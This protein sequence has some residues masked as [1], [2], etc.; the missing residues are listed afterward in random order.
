MV[1][2]I[3]KICDEFL[4]Y[5]SF[6]FRQKSIEDTKSISKS[7]ANDL[8]RTKS[9][10]DKPITHKKST[11]YVGRSRLTSIEDVVDEVEEKQSR[12]KSTTKG[13][14]S[15]EGVQRAKSVKH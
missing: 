3:S 13:Y 7:N 6:H 14:H 10:I 4:N 11:S 12:S 8:R 2:K 5:V 9:L 1:K 15:Y